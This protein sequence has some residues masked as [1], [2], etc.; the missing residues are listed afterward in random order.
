MRPH[1]RARAWEST[2]R[3]HISKNREINKRGRSPKKKEEEEEQAV[4]CLTFLN[5][6][7]ITT[8]GHKHMEDNSLLARSPLTHFNNCN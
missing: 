3:I 8:Q 1:A 6:L 4:F 7:E 5:R 2:R